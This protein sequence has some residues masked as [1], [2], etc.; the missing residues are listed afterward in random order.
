[1]SNLSIIRQ[2]WFCVNCRNNIFPFNSTNTHD[3]LSDSF[4]SNELCNDALKD[5][6]VY[7][8]LETITEL[9]LQSLPKVVG[10]P[11]PF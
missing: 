3:I 7:K 9:K 2:Q 4:N 5:L 1:M 8:C 6:T 11:M 10:T